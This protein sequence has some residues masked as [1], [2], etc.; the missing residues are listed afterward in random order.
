M[1]GVK[2]QQSAHRRRKWRVL[3]NL[4][5]QGTLI[6]VS[7][8]SQDSSV[9]LCICFSCG[10]FKDMFGDDH[11]QLRTVYIIAITIKRGERSE[12]PVVELNVWD[13]RHMC[14]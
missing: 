6:T 1:S 10:L 7:S 8:L 9:S 2:V 4:K 3:P 12:G 13:V 14:D 5:L 11:E